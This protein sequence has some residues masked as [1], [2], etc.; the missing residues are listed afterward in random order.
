MTPPVTCSTAGSIAVIE[1]N[2]PPV[3]ALSQAVRQGLRDA[4]VQADADAAITA[5]VII[6]AGR[7][8]PA[9]ADI[10]EFGQPMQDPHLPDVIDRI[11]SCSKPVVA[12]LHGTALGGG[13]EIALGSHYRI[14]APSAQVGL[15]EIHLGLIPGAG[16]T[17][18][19]PRLCGAAMALD[20]MFKGTPI[21]ATQALSAGLIDRLAEGDLRQ[22]AL[23]YAAELRSPRSTKDATSG[24][25][26]KAGFEAALR[27][28]EQTAHRRMRGQMAPLK[29]VDCLRACITQPFAEGRLFERDCFFECLASEQS[30]GMIHAFFAQRASAKVPEA[31]RAE[32]RPLNRLGVVG[33]GTMGAGIT[34]AALNSGLPVTMIERDQ[35]SLARGR[36][37]VEQ[38]YDRLIAKGRMNAAQ[39]S[40]IM[41]RYSGSTEFADLS[42]VDMVIEAVFER[43]DVKRGVF[44]QLD[45]VLKPDAVLA[46]NTSYI[47][48]D[49]ISS[50]TNRRE[51]VLG[52]HFFSPANIMKLLEIVVPQSAADDV[53]ATGFALAKTLGKI[54]VRAGNSPG[55]IGNRILGKYGECAAHMMEDGATPYEIDAAI[56][57]FGYPMGLHA[58]YDLAGLDIG[59]DNRKAAEDTRNPAERYV[60]I[61]DRICE[62]GWFG[63][64]SGRCFYLYPNG[65]RI[66]A[67]DP[68][69]LALIEA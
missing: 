59:W 16:G 10:K 25:A 48:I 62:C 43:L 38:V 58:M 51:H 42:E 15:P 9:G 29:I 53:V 27:D 61:A 39:K 33:G 63:Q 2:N 26:D 52:L 12:A 47:D 14:A 7:S 18:R 57:E 22:A 55:F 35:E 23:I 24:L 66:G 31:S 69:I 49:E 17:Q 13:F 64:K 11:E 5:I 21:G 44:E 56:V 60:E 32:P 19:L 50:A 40:S 65:A 54:P 6:G 36:A 20:I 28:A 34:V 68:E 8:F 67:P 1:I 46:S 30:K 37:N 4:V 41:A 3:N 45:K